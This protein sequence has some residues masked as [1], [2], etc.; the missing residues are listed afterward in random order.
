MH[1]HLQLERV[2]F[3]QFTIVD[4]RSVSDMIYR[5]VEQKHFLAF[6]GFQP[7]SQDCLSPENASVLRTLFDRLF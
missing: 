4:L 1:A 7:T 3:Y 5:I 6:L 2:N